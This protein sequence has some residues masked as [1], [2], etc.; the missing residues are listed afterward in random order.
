VQSE[1]EVGN[2][3]CDDDEAVFMA[4]ASPGEMKMER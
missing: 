2:N 3:A 1:E 4:G